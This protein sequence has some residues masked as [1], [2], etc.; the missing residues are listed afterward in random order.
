MAVTCTPRERAQNLAL[1]DKLVNYFKSRGLLLNLHSRKIL[2]I[3]KEWASIQGDKSAEFHHIHRAFTPLNVHEKYTLSI[4]IN[5]LAR[6]GNRLQR[7][8]PSP[9]VSKPQL[10][11]MQR[12]GLIPPRRIVLPS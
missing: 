5:V 7:L 10:S 1:L 11:C 9:D 2:W 4:W 8:E 3:I 6:L 12:L